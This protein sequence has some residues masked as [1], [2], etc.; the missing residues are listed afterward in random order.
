MSTIHF[1][2]EEVGLAAEYLAAQHTHN[3]PL[4]DALEQWKNEVWFCQF[5]NGLADFCE[6]NARA[7]TVRYNEAA[8]AVTAEEILEWLRNT[9]QYMRTSVHGQRTQKAARQLV[10]LGEYNCD[11][12]ELS[13]QALAALMALARLLIL[14]T[15]NNR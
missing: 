8:R 6:A 2:I 7:Y 12:Q 14:E 15:E 5:V 4:S 13:G 9:P 1:D 3:Q 11:D 10:I